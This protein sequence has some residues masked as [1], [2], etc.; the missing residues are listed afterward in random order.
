LQ[1]SNLAFIQGAID[2]LAGDSNLIAVRSRAVRERPFTV[3]NK[4]QA[5]AEARF[6]SK[7]KELEAGLASAQQR[8]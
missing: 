7:I 6:Q 5:D 1:G 8:S 2:Q 4:M 3:V